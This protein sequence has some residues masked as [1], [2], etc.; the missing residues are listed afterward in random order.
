M[1]NPFN[2]QAPIPGIK[3]I[4][5]VSSGKGGV[6]KSTV[7]ANLAVALVKS[8]ATV[9]LLDCDIYGPS[10]PRLFGA[11]N[12]K[13]N[14]N[15]SGKLLPIERYGVKLMSLGFLVEENAAVI[16]RGPM[17]FKTIDQF[18]KDVVWG[19]LDYLVIDLPP[20]TG[21]VQLTLAQ[22]VP[23]TGA[24]TVTTPQ[25]I[26][27]ADV[28]KSI[29]MFSRVN[30]PVLGVVENMAYFEVPGSQ[31][32]VQLFP[33]GE[34]D[35]YLD[36]SRIEKISVLPFFTQLAK[37]GEIGIPVCE[38]SPKSTEAQAFSDLALKVRKKIDSL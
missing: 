29:D 1:S 30:V 6:G 16:W 24:L 38:S 33:K 12:Q 10:I 27:L 18:L 32:K 8:G 31:E 21:D 2:N 11:I 23:M 7:S 26:A 35:S 34:L 22:T 5:A 36:K 28:K 13:P 37:S 25:N 17:L 19:D 4:I 15:E 20:G 3:H 14:L 9:G